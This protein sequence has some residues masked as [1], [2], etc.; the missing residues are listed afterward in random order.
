MVPVSAVGGGRLGRYVNMAGTVGDQGVV[1]MVRVWADLLPIHHQAR[2]VER[3]LHISW[4]EP[5]QSYTIQ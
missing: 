5:T 3:N 2:E 1:D 4:P